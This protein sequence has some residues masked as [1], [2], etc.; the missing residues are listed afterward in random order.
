[1]RDSA[2]Y[3]MTRPHQQQHISASTLMAH[4]GQRSVPHDSPPTKNN[5]SASTLNRWSPQ[6]EKGASRGVGKV[7]RSTS[8][9]VGIVPCGTGVW[10]ASGGTRT[11]SSL[12]AHLSDR[13]CGFSRLACM[14]VVGWESG[15]MRY[16]MPQDSSPPTTTTY[17]LPR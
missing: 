9:S 4:E 11:R 6:D 8:V 7:L 1:M 2:A 14:L 16:I 3:L 17:Q 5:I 10:L 15:Y 12:L 13:L